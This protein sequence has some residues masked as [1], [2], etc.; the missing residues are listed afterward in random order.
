M[1]F[2]QN[3]DQVPS[4]D[5]ASPALNA[6]A[7]L[8]N[9]VHLQRQADATGNSDLRWQCMEEIPAALEEAERVLAEAAKSPL[10]YFSI[11]VTDSGVGASEWQSAAARQE[12]HDKEVIKRPLSEPSGHYLVD[13]SRTGDLVDAV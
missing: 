11:S 5:Y 2:D 4:Q 9:L 3:T 7:A 8:A 1:P 10:R 12:W 6:L 13:I